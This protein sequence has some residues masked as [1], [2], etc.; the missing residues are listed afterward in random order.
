MEKTEPGKVGS[1]LHL[2]SLRS[3]IPAMPKDK[4]KKLLLIED[5]T[6][7]KY[8]GLFTHPWNLRSEE[9]AREFS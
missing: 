7:I 2:V 5:L 9:M 1:E 6:Q 8:E 4:A 3:M